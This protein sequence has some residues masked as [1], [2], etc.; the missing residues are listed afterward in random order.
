MRLQLGVH[1]EQAGEESKPAANGPNQFYSPQWVPQ[2]LFQCV[3]ECEGMRRR[4]RRKVRRE[5]AEKEV[6]VYMHR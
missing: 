4:R 5:H 1:D 6:H 3:R 2:N